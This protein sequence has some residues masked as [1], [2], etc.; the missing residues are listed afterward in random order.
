MNRDTSV[1]ED[2]ARVLLLACG[3]TISS[4]RAAPGAGAFHVHGMQA[5]LG[6]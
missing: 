6:E 2:L 5:A 3:G 4:V 1:S